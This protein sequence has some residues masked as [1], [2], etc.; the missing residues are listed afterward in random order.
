MN[1]NNNN[2]KPPSVRLTLT[3]KELSFLVGILKTAN[4]SGGGGEIAI[5]HRLGIKL[6]KAGISAGISS[7]FT[8]PSSSM[9]DNDSGDDNNDNMPALSNSQLKANNLLLASIKGEVISDE[10]R[11]WY[12]QETGNRL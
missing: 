11:E 7:S 8:G 5:V 4:L 1:T 9:Q 12:Y 10:D 3:T 6:A 2:I